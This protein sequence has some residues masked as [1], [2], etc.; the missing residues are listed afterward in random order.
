MSEYGYIRVSTKDQNEAR[1]VDAM[2]QIGVTSLFID[3][4]S[5]KDFDRPQYKR[6][7]KKLKPGDVI[8]IL[9]LDR[10]GRNYDEIREQW[11]YITDKKNAHIHVIDM[12]LLDTRKGGDLLSKFIADLVLQ[13]LAYVAQTE[14]EAIKKRQ[15]EGI[16]SAR[17]RGVRLG[18]KRR[19][20]PEVF[21]SSA[22]AY[23]KGDLTLEDAAQRCS[24]TASNF[25]YHLCKFKFGGLQC[26]G[27]EI[28]R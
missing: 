11:L 10:L 6:M 17:V 24:M 21:Y 16:E 9:S 2:N 20:L 22:N 26:Q 3:K 8:H 14:R 19:E 12:P 23:K 28:A 5:G 27:T 4:A 18:R 1:Q 25:R 15:A 13:I 7:V